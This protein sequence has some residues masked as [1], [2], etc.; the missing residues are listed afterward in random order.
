MNLIEQIM[1]GVSASDLAAEERKR[2]AKEAGDAAAKA[3]A[4]ALSGALILRFLSRHCQNF[5]MHLEVVSQGPERDGAGMM[6]VFRYPLVT[7]LTASTF[8]QLGRGMEACVSLLKKPS[9][10]V[11]LHELAGMLY[12][13]ELVSANFRA[14]SFC[15]INLTSLLTKESDYAAF[16]SAFKSCVMQLAEESDKAAG[17]RAEAAT[18][19]E[20]KDLWVTVTKVSKEIMASS[21]R[22]LHK[23]P[24]EILA[25]LK[26]SLASGD[27][28][29]CQV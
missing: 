19:E 29:K 10:E 4:Q 11:E 26:A 8:V 13:L 14:L 3:H 22:L 27:G 20:A 24:G 15:S 9:K 2:A 25:S 12:L 21:I 6:S 1:H 7:Y 23:G 5:K 16:M 17:D 18:D 28:A